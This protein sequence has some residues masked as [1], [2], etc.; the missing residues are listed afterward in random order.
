MEETLDSILNT[1]QNMTTASHII[2]NYIADLTPSWNIGDHSSVNQNKGKRQHQGIEKEPFSYGVS[3]CIQ[4]FKRQ[5]KNHSTFKASIVYK[6]HVEYSLSY[7]TRPS[8]KTGETAGPG[9]SL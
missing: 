5:K 8:L 7:I 6:S 3:L 1:P 4:V 2:Y 9:G